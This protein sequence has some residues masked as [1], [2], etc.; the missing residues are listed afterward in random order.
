M[1]AATLHASIASP[2]P[3]MCEHAIAD[4]AEDPARNG[5]DADEAG[6]TG[7]TSRQRRIE[8]TTADSVRS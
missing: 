6:G 4:E 2:A 3:K 7:E 5:G 8:R 1:R